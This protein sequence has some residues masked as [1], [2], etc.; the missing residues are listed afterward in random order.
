MIGV[1]QLSIFV[2]IGL[3]T[4]LF[5]LASLLLRTPIGNDGISPAV[6]DAALKYVQI[7][8][9]GMLAATMIG[10]AQAA[11]MGMQDVKSP[12]LGCSTHVWFQRTVQHRVQR[13]GSVSRTGRFRA[14]C[15]AQA[16][17]VLVVDKQSISYR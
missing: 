6:F 15:T 9:L 11:C 17:C 14:Q 10:S 16:Q 3:G 5:C 12:L 4:V 13:T 2:G 1:L 7:R 8:A